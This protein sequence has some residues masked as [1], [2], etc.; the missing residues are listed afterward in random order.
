MKYDKTTWKKERNSYHH[1]SG[2][3]SIRP[4]YSNIGQGDVVGYKIFVYNDNGLMR[5]CKQ[6][7]DGE[8]TAPE[9]MQKAIT[10]IN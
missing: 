6:I 8:K 9:T 1:I 10:Y 7:L 4:V 5:E 2:K 3:L